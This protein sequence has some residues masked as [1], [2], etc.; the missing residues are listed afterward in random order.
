MKRLY[1]LTDSIDC[2]EQ[3]ASEVHRWGI[4][5]WNYHVLSK[6]PAGLSKHQNHADT[7]LHQKSIVPTCERGLFTGIA[8]GVAAALGAS[9]L[10]PLLETVG[11]IP[12]A[13]VVFSCALL[14]AWSIALFGRY[15]EQQKLHKFQH[16]IDSGK[17]L[18]MIDVKKDQIELV[19]KV[20]GQYPEALPAMLNGG[21][22]RTLASAK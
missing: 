10:I 3:I 11:R 6:D 13:I 2:A 9:L 15:E 17:L 21:V 14:G 19:R 18:I 5:D 12:F 8:A 7:L 22:S 20:M 4:A 1:Y 16:D